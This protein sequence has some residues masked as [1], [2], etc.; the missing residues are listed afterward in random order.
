MQLSGGCRSRVNEN[1]QAG[2]QAL[3]LGFGIS[4]ACLR[5]PQTFR[6]PR[7]IMDNAD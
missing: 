4:F 5:P 7:P 6:V 3:Q 1:H 2:C